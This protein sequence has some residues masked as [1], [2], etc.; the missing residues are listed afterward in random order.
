MSVNPLSS[1]LRWL[2]GMLHSVSSTETV[3][4]SSIGPP[5]GPY[6]GNRRARMV[7]SLGRRG[8]NRALQP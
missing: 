4:G 5:S 6:D 7:T 2:S 1:C 8:T 3:G